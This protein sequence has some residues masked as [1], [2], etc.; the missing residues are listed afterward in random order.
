M[1]S[2]FQVMNAAVKLRKE[3]RGDPPSEDPQWLKE[4]ALLDFLLFLSKGSHRGL[5]A[6]VE[7]DVCAYSLLLYMS[8]LQINPDFHQ[9]RKLI[10]T[11]VHRFATLH[12]S[13][14]APSPSAPLSD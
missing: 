3:T 2:P 8:F 4:D 11:H 1:F 12:P 6:P 9:E 7:A 10:I 13:A 14:A 5:F